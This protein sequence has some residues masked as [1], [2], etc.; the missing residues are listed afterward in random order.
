MKVEG[1]I[2]FD[3]ANLS[4]DELIEL[5]KMMKEKID[6]NR[7]ALAESTFDEIFVSCDEGEDEPCLTDRCSERKTVSNIEI[8]MTRLT[9]QLE[10]F[11]LLNKVEY[12]HTIT[13]LKNENC[14][15]KDKLAKFDI[16]TKQLEEAI[17]ATFEK[18]VF[19]FVRNS[20]GITFSGFLIPVGQSESV[21]GIYRS[22]F[23]VAKM[24]RTT[25][26]FG[27]CSMA[28]QHKK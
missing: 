5:N 20:S 2:Q 22:L 10:H 11:K 1:R 17:F 25:L 19:T 18:F 26:R 6:Q 7:S 8:V 27:W 14:Q 21:S 24:C 3:F 13:Q 15:M 12:E 4:T 16:Q 9:N 28:L 23:I